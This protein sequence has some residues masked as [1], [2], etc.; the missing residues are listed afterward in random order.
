M[1]GL[2]GILAFVYGAG[3]PAVPGIVKDGIEVDPNGPVSPTGSMSPYGSRT[4]QVQRDSRGVAFAPA[5]LVRGPGGVITNNADPVPGATSFPV[6][7]YPDEPA[8]PE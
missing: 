6:T 1:Y 4:N 5:F 3:V 7:H 8:G 2:I